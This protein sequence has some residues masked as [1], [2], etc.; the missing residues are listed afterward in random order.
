[1]GP[2]APR[3]LERGKV[4][5]WGSDKLTHSILKRAIIIIILSPVE[6]YYRR[7]NDCSSNDD[8]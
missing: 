4:T 6:N 3:S 8:G 5:E 7:N 1:M 2:S